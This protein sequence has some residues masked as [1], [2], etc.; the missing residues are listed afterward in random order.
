MRSMPSCQKN[1][2]LIVIMSLVR[3]GRK[4]EERVNVPVGVNLPLIRGYLEATIGWVH[5][6]PYG[7]YLKVALNNI[8]WLEKC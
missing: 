6:G 1:S 8:R 7:K 2:D 4:G 3:H 5:C